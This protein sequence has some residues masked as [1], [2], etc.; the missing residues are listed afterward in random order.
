MRACILY[1]S[2]HM[3]LYMCVYVYV[4]VRQCVLRMYECVKE[5]VCVC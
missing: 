5:C 4:A 2:V 1:V 3:R